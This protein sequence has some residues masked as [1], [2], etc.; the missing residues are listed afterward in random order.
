[1]GVLLAHP[2]DKED[3]VVHGQAEQDAEQDDGEK[4]QHRLRG[5]DREEAVEMAF[6]EDI[7]HRA[8]CREDA[9]DVAGHRSKWDEQ[10]AEDQ[11]QDQHTQNDDDREIGR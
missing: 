10:R 7:G 9:E 8:E 3:L 11:Q 4:A 1:M 5:G 2:G 6:L